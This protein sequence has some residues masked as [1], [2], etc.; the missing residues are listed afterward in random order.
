MQH[1]KQSTDLRVNTATYINLN[2]V[3]PGRPKGEINLYIG[4]EKHQLDQIAAR[5]TRVYLEKDMAFSN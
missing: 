1:V 2:N 4:F 3:V 5:N